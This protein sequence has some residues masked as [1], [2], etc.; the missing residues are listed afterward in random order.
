MTLAETL[1]SFKDKLNLIELARKL[2]PYITHPVAPGG[3]FDGT[4]DDITDGTTYVKTH[5]DFTDAAET[6]LS[7]IATGATVYTDEMVRDAMGIALQEGTNISLNVSDIDNTITVNCTVAVPDQL[8]DLSDDTT[9]RLV[10]DTQIGDFHSPGSDNQDLSGLE[11]VY[12]EIEITDASGANAPYGNS[13]IYINIPT[14]EDPP[15]AITFS[16]TADPD[17]TDRAKCIVKVIGINAGATQVL[18]F[19]DK[20]DVTGANI[21]LTDADNG[22]S[23]MFVYFRGYW[24]TIF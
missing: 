14:L 13:I 20:L 7:G 8:S 15:S 18:D 22:I 4:M 1:R 17:D 16:L 10:T 9:H 11:P 12:T 6:K 19:N 24:R 23:L 3:A 5:N 21:E 2:D